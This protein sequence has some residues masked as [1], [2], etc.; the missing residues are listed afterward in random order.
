MKLCSQLH[1]AQRF[2]VALGL[3]HAEISQQLL[4]GIAAFLLADDH[5]RLAFE[6]AH[7]GHDRFIVAKEAVPM[8]FFETTEKALNVIERVRALWMAS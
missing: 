2:A 5:N 6:E 8:Q 3:R 7:A 1:D 4:F